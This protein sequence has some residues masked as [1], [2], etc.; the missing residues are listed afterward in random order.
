MSEHFDSYV[1]SLAGVP[2]E[3]QGI[4]AEIA[5]RCQDYRTAEK[6]F[7]RVQ[8]SPE[9]IEREREQMA[10][11]ARP[12]ERKNQNSFDLE[13]TALCRRISEKMPEYGAFLF[14]GSALAIDG[15]AYI[16]T[17]KSGTGKST[18]ARLW[19]ELLCERVVMVND[20]KPFLRVYNDGTVMAYGS[21]W[22]G[23]H[24]LSSNIAVPVRAICILEQ[25][26][27]NHIRKH[28]RRHYH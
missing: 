16:F 15:A 6:P 13:F 2:V 3:I 9:D 22:N 11:I 25:S 1:L 27:E 20:D 17:A 8:I 4:S 10:R 24:H 5:G 12:E 7:F 28:W 19:R 14:H 26:P 18:H 23:K 21:P